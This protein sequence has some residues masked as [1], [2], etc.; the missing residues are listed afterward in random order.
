VVMGLNPRRSSC[1]PQEVVPR[2]GTHEV[3][4]PHLASPSNAAGNEGECEHEVRHRD[5]GTRSVGK[6]NR[7]TI[8]ILI[9]TITASDFECTCSFE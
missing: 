3:R 1:E 6:P 9:A 2:I 4:V 5:T 8:P 7:H